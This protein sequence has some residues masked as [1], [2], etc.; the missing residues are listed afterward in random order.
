VRRKAGVSLFIIVTYGSVV[1]RGKI[2]VGCYTGGGQKLSRRFWKNGL[3]IWR[4]AKKGLP[5][6]GCRAAIT[7]TYC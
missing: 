3:A 1:R 6:K 5:K 2:R 4:A 7:S